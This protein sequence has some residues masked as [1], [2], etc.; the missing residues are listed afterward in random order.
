MGAA[1]RGVV[2]LRTSR[3]TADFAR[4]D[5]LCNEAGI[6]LHYTRDA[7]GK[8]T[9]DW[10]RQIKPE[11]IFCFG[12]SRL[13]SAELLAIPPRGV[14]GYHP[15]LLP[16]NRGRHPIIWA[17]ALGLKETG[18][19][20]FYMDQSA[21]SGDILSQ[22]HI[23]ITPDDDAGTLYRRL[24]ETAL[25][26]I[27]EFLPLL[28]NGVAPRIPQDSAF[29]STWRKRNF[30]DGRIDWRMPADAIHNLVR[31]LAPPY[32][33]AT[34]RRGKEDQIVWRTRIDANNARHNTEP[35]K[36]LAIQNNSIVVK[37]GDGT[38][39]LTQHEIDPLPR[40]GEYL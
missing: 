20:F 1:P 11:L 19:T 25:D 30:S 31:A 38:V 37:V 3:T 27:T 17:L 21:D 5:D 14:I 2:T 12:W 23:P 29:A 35:G 13:L 34:V 6:S 16:Q 4:L 32:S 18:S 22:H 28:G 40:V 7:N 33:G 26:Q 24:T 10:L 39:T 9:L 15:A 8:E 36:V